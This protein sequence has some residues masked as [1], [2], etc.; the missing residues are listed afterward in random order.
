MRQFPITPLL[1]S[2]PGPVTSK[3]ER[4]AGCCL[5]A[6][7]TPLGTGHLNAPDRA[8]HVQRLVCSDESRGSL[9]DHPDFRIGWFFAYQWRNHASDAA[10]LNLHQ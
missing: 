4:N 2:E 6:G 8:A 1:A 3:A 5:R 7:S 9:V 10:D